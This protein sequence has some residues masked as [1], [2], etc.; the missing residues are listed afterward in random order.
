MLN[1][2]YSFSVSS[3]QKFIGHY[4]EVWPNSVMSHWLA[5]CAGWSK[6]LALSKFV[7][8][9]FTFDMLW[10]LEKI[11]IAGKNESFS[12]LKL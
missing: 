6:L 4:R 2:L 12:H 9:H 7:T 10:M 8:L 5:G 3:T 11:V 1:Y